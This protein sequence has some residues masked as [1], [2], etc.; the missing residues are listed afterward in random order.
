MTA[1]ASA[2]PS[3]AGPSSQTF[4]VMTLNL[5]FGRA[6]DGPNSWKF[7]KKCLSS[8]FSRFNPDFI[9][10]QEVNDFQLPFLTRVLPGHRFIGRR[11]PAPAF[12]QNNILFYRQKWRCTFESHF[13]LSPT[14]E[15]PSRFRN[16]RW[17]RQCTMGMFACPGRRLACVDTHLD[18]DAGVQRNS[19][20]LIL[21][22]LSPLPAAA[23]VI[24]MGDFNTDC[25]SPC[26]G[27]LTGR[28]DDEGGFEDVFGGT[29]PGTHHGFTGQS[30]GR[31][32]DWI[33][34]RGDLKV[35]DVQV[36]RERFEGRYPSDHFPLVAVFSWKD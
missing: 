24:L 26:Y 15:V 33:L 1:M 7:R 10:L 28:K 9:G 6:D 13:F 5:R 36:I 12:W 32:I 18:F 14:P 4:T 23:P 20:R 2:P 11:R 25:H 29:C 17:P 19:G 31:A 22:R 3:S 16:S 34:F 35:V 30:N 8:L 27:L 21:S